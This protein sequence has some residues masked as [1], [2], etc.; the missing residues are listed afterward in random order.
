MGNQDSTPNSPEAQEDWE[1]L[2]KPQTPTDGEN[3]IDTLPQEVLINIFRYIYQDDKQSTLNMMLV[4]QRWKI[5]IEAFHV[6]DLSRFF[7]KRRNIQEY[8][9]ALNSRRQYR[10]FKMILGN[11]NDFGIEWIENVFNHYEKT[12][13]EVDIDISQNEGFLST[14]LNLQG[15]SFEYMYKLLSVFKNLED[16]TIHF[17]DMNVNES[18]DMERPKIVFGKLKSFKIYWTKGDTSINRF[19]L[20]YMEA[21]SLQELK[22]DLP[23]RYGPEEAYDFFKF[24]NKNSVNLKRAYIWS[25]DTYGF[26]WTGEYLEI[27]SRP[28]IKFEILEFMANRKEKLKTFKLHWMD[29]STF[30]SQVFEAAKNLENFETSENHSVYCSRQCHKNIKML[31]LWN[32]WNDEQA[33]SRVQ[34]TFPD[35]EVMR[36]AYSILPAETLNYIREIFTK[37]K[38]IRIYS[39]ATNCYELVEV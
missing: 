12:L 38:E 27:W 15:F 11:E 26:D 18:N 23:S 14:I 37:L 7:E 8:L 1:M 32:F 33:I 20:N 25:K 34:T 9:F 3:Y 2:I 5:L 36:F 39:S 16:V 13:R 30:V 4:C 24:L 29:D 28:Q 22:I 19:I 6:F 31:T 35:V 10:R 21:P 17:K